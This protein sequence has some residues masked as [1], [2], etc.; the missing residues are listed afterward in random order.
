[1][2]RKEKCEE[3]RK[4]IC[5]GTGF[6]YIYIYKFYYVFFHTKFLCCLIIDDTDNNHC[7]M[8]PFLFLFIL[9]L[10]L[11]VFLSCDNITIGGC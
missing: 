6:T 2:G 9:A 5:K 1:M 10:L 7:L 11:Y 8:N 3:I 4:G